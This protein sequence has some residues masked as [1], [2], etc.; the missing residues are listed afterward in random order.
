MHGEGSRLL[1]VP[2]S[3]GHLGSQI[4]YYSH[5][6]QHKQRARLIVIQGKAQ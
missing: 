5:A 1:H 6:D 2:L 4:I 3:F